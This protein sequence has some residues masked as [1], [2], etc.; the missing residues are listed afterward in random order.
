[1]RLS[2]T[3][4]RRIPPFKALQARLLDL[5]NDRLILKFIKNYIDEILLYYEELQE[6][7]ELN[8]PT[9]HPAIEKIFSTETICRLYLWMFN[10]KQFE[11]FRMEY[12][13]FLNK[14]FKKMK[15]YEVSSKKEKAE[16]NHYFIWHMIVPAKKM[17]DTLSND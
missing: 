6:H 9:N 4:L 2:R 10:R 13:E 11:V 7:V 17:Y 12:L 3:E 15:I 8:P 1:M 16:I 14:I 5:K